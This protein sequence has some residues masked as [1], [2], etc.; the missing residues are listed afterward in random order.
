METKYVGT[1]IVTK[2]DTWPNFSIVPKY[3][4]FLRSN[5]CQEKLEKELL[6]LL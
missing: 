5:S 2:E 4:T 3:L 1:F 6:W